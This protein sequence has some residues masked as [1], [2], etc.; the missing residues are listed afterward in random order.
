MSGRVEPGIKL[1]FE[2]VRQGLGDWKIAGLI[3]PNYQQLQPWRLKM[4]TASQ[5]S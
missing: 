5:T 1:G 4:L 3:L 2:M